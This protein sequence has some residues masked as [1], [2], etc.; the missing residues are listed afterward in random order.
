M[1]LVR[2]CQCIF[3]LPYSIRCS[4]WPVQKVTQAWLLHD[5]RTRVS[6]QF[7]ESIV[8]KYYRLCVHLCIR[9][10]K[11]PIWKIKPNIL[12]VMNIHVQSSMI[13]CILWNWKT[14]VYMNMYLWLIWAY[15]CMMSKVKWWCINRSIQKNVHGCSK[16]DGCRVS[17]ALFSVCPS[18]RK[19]DCVSVD[20]NVNVE[21]WHVKNGRV[22]MSHVS[23][24]DPCIPP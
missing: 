7:T 4:K 17:L 15:M 22:G 5:L 12:N 8:T 1:L 18:L 3:N 14:Y 21:K 24:V 13:D 19:L 23:N 6:T 9:N 20:K 10:N 16:M 11:V 2:A